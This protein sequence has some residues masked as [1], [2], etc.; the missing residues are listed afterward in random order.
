M[1]PYPGSNGKAGIQQNIWEGVTILQWSKG[2]DT[3]L[4]LCA[5]SGPGYYSGNLH[6]WAANTHSSGEVQSIIDSLG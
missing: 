2:F 4:G 6:R 1:P 3:A 5:L